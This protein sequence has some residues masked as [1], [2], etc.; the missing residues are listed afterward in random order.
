MVN[1]NLLLSKIALYGDTWFVLAKKIGIYPAT[2]H[3]KLR[4]ETDFKA[5]EIKKIMEIYKL[6]PE[7]IVEIFL[8][9]GAVKQ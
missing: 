8:A 1:K 4:G 7:E 6:T 2:L 9:N 5:G 3:K